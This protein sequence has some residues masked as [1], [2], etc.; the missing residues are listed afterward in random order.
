M[1]PGKIFSHIFFLV[2]N[3]FF[4]FIFRNIIFLFYTFFILIRFTQ[5]DLHSYSTVER[6][7]KDTDREEMKYSSNEIN[8]ALFI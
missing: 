4:F 3:I 1:D 5:M 2:I 6:I 8:M 7:K